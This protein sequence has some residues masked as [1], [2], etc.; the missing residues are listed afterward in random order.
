[1]KRIIC[2]LAL[3]LVFAISE[4]FAQHNMM[5]SMSDNGNKKDPALAALLSIQPFPVAAGNFYS[6]NWERGILYTT[7]EVALFIPAMILLG[8]NG[9]GMHNY[10]YYN[11]TDNRLSWTVEER[12]QFYYLLTGY[13]VV[14]IV[15]A[16][17][18]GY[19]V[20]E[21]NKHFSMSYNAQTNSEMLSFKIPLN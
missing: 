7:A 2:L 6:G 5:G 9:W 3:G 11:G 20:E 4:V 17:D 8:R 21:Y 1:M 13:I 15:S 19:S 10:N 16:F 14:K 18:A 12:N